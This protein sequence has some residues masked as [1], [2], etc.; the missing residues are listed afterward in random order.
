MNVRNSNVVSLHFAF[1]TTKFED[2]SL[3]V[4]S[5]YYPD[6]KTV[7]EKQ[8]TQTPGRPTRNPAPLVSEPLL[9]SYIVQITNALKAVHS[10]QLAVRV[11]EPTKVIVTDENRIRLN[12]C[13]LED[14]LDSDVHDILDLQRLD[15]HKFGNFIVAVGTNNLSSSS[16]KTRAMD[17]FAQNYFRNSPQLKVVVDWLLDHIRPENNEGIDVLVG[18]VSSNAIDAFDSSLRFNDQLYF[19]LNKEVEN[20]RIVRLM[21]K[22]NCL[23]NRSEYEHDRT[24][25]T[26]GSRAVLGL[27]RDY[28]FHQVDAQANPVVDMGHI[29]SCLNKLDAGIEERIVLTTRDDQNVN[30]VSYKELKGALESTWQ[31]LVRRSTG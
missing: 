6:S 18:L 22:L 27:F 4:V 29:L 3:V 24:Y 11:I 25:S 1:T 8:F 23:N 7:A 2:S 30:I 31:E 16:S 26:Q 14:L 13:A 19:S 9:W 21:T 28:V 12:G 5:D 17:V 15:F 20:S 10:A